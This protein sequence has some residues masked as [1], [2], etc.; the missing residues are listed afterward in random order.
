M[1]FRKTPFNENDLQSIIMACLSGNS[2]A[3]KALI[4]MFFSYAK[5]VCMPYVS[6]KEEAEEVINDCFL[7]VFTHLNKF[8][9]SRPFKAWF[10]SILI[11]TAIDHY[12]KNNQPKY[13]VDV[14][15]A[16]DLQDGTDILGKISADEI[17]ALIQKLP[18]SYRMVFNLYVIDGY[19][20]REI[21]EMLGIGEGTSKSN[22]RDARR[23]LQVM[24][25]ESQP[26]L[27]LAYSLKNSRFHEN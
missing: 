12:R 6:C 24:I 13:L 3:Q 19:T 8:D 27:F 14:D 1:F 11:N 5:H 10:K 16:F 25:A 23:K 15:Q 9:H 26:H 7:K 18:P 21:A 4:K 17:I 22:L 2:S 20:H